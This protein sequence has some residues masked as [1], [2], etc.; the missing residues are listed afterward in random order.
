MTA[1]GSVAALAAQGVPGHDP[2]DGSQC[3]E[4]LPQVSPFSIRDLL[5]ANDGLYGF[6]M[7]FI[8]EHAG[9]DWTYLHVP[10]T[11]DG[12]MFCRLCRVGRVHRPQVRAVADLTLFHTERR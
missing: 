6:V 10:S 12:G 2:G 8:E 7:R 11:G 4:Q 9:H 5:L 1:N 3:G